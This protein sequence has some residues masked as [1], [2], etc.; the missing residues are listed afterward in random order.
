MR[1]LSLLPLLALMILATATGTVVHC[2]FAQTSAPGAMQTAGASAPAATEAATR[3]TFTLGKETTRISTPLLADGRPDYATAL[4]RIEAQ[5][6][7]PENNVLAGLVEVLGPEAIWEKVRAE[8]LK[9]LG[10][11]GETKGPKFREFADY[12]NK[13]GQRDAFD[14]ARARLAREPWEQEDCPV[15]AKWLE[16]NRE[17]LDRMAKATER[18]RWYCP[19]VAATDRAGLMPIWRLEIVNETGEIGEGLAMR[20]MLRLGQGQMDECQADLLSLHRLGRAMTRGQ[21]RWEKILGMNTDLLA[22]LGDAALAKELQPKEAKAYLAKLEKLPAIRGW[23]EAFDVAGRYTLLDTSLSIAKYG[24]PGLNGV[25]I[26]PIDADAFGSTADVNWDVVLKR[27][28]G[29]C[30][31]MVEA[32][33][34][35]TYAE[36]KAAMGAME[37]WIAQIKST[38]DSHAPADST[39][40]V[41]DLL[42]FT[43][44]YEVSR[45]YW[46]YA[47]AAQAR[48][49]LGMMAVA[50]GAYRGEKGEYPDN[51][52]ALTPGYLK[53]VPEDVFGHAPLKYRREGKGYVL[54]SIGPDMKGD[55]RAGSRPNGAIEFVIMAD[56]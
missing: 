9:R 20:A 45:V 29:L 53:A 39:Q 52:D 5:G 25:N 47:E 43:A 31:G 11:S 17:A 13:T 24:G 33:G 15:I 40:R 3:P 32:M 30:D 6:V 55:G 44:V 10:V 49:D 28:N 51:L 7:L 19:R 38:W 42:A 23:A 56:R 18:E 36:R 54:Y 14:L 16:I 21:C 27:M 4:D 46:Q 26:G 37:D 35:P 50:L 34:K 12:L 2:A 8:M 41:G 22:S 1:T 48:F